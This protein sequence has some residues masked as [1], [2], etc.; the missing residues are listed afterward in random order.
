MDFLF[1]KGRSPWVFMDHEATKVGA[2]FDRDMAH[3]EALTAF[4]EKALATG[5]VE[6]IGQAETVDAESKV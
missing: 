3:G 1:V 2:L 6:H 5:Q 4:D